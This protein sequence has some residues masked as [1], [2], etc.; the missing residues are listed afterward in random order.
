M[1]RIA[2]NFHKHIGF[3]ENSDGTTV[4]VEHRKLRDVR[5]AHAFERGQQSV[6]RSDGDDFAGFV[7]MGDQITQIAMGRAMD[8]TLLGHPE[9]VVHLREIFVP[10]VD[11]ES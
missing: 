9:I 1:H 5:T 10:G 8:E 3:I 4:L 2:V 11:D 7:T 6:R